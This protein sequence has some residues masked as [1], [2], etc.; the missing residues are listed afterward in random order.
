M[1]SEERKLGLVALDTWA[2]AGAMRT[3]ADEAFEV[4]RLLEHVL[5]M[6]ELE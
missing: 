5:L 4:L 3:E 6:R 1:E 2:H